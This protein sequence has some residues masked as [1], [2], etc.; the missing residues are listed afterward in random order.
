MTHRVS[1][2]ELPSELLQVAGT[3]T[4]EKI[5]EYVQ[6]ESNCCTSYQMPRD[7]RANVLKSAIQI[8]ARSTYAVRTGALAGNPSDC[9]E[10]GLRYVPSLLSLQLTGKTVAQDVDRL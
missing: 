8:K 1:Y 10:L 7:F 2:Q 9:L 4:L 5:M 3:D 6:F